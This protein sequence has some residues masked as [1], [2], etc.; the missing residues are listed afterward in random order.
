MK[1]LIQIT[2]GIAIVSAFVFIACN[3]DKHNYRL[4][5]H[6]TDAPAAYDEVNVDIESIKVKLR[7]DSAGWVSLD[8][9]AGI[10]NLLG[11]QGVDSL[12]AS[13]TLP[14]NYVQEI[15]FYLG[16]N[17]TIKVAGQTYPLVMDNGTQTKLMIK[18]N[19]QI[20]GT[21]DSLTLDWD[22]GL[23]VVQEGNGTYRLSPVITVKE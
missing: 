16:T 8:T 11:L 13:G 10:Y 12:I 6:L 9:K 23:S 15:R 1:R 7:D 14:S 21:L 17:N 22:A 18:V 20:N 2:L 3:K 4:D 19:K 5:V